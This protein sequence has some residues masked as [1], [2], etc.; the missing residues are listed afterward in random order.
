M[1]RLRGLGGLGGHFE[2]VGCCDLLL[3]II[4]YEIYSSILFILFVKNINK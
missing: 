1:L 2:Q 3:I 4:V